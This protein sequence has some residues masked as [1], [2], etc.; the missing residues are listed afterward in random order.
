MKNTLL[1][2]LSL[3]CCVNIATAQLYVDEFDDGDASAVTGGA[4]YSFGEANGELTVTANG[5]SGPF[6]PFVINVHDQ[7]NGD[8]IT[9]DATGNNIVF[10]RA[11]ASNNG[12]QFRMDMQD[13]AGFATTLPGFTV[14][15]TTDYQVF[16]FDFTDNYL[17]GGFGGT[18][19]DS[20]DAPC[21]VDGTMI[22]QFIM[23]VNPQ[24]GGF[25][26]QVVIDYIAFGEEPGE[27]IMSDIFQDHM[28][29]DSSLTGFVDPGVGYTFSQ[30]GTEVIIV[31]D[32]S[33]GAWDPFVFDF[34]NETTYETTDID[35]TGNNKIYVKAKS[36]VAGTALRMDAQ[37]IDG[38]VS[39][40]GSITKLLTDADEYQILEYDYTG[41]LADLGF[42]GTPCT[43]NTAPCPVD[44]ERIANLTFFI[45]PGVGEY[46]GALTI[47][48]I[49]VGTSLEP[50]G[51]EAE[52][53]YSDHFNNETVDFVADAGGFV[54]S[55]TGSEWTIDGDG[56]A[57]A[58]SA[59]AY[60]FHDMI[61]GEG[62]LLDLNP[63]QGKVF[64]RAKTSGGT[65]PLR[66]DLVD[67]TGYVTS[68]PAL[69]K[70]VSDEYE[71]F[72][73][74]FSG[75]YIDGGYGGTAC[76]E[77]EGP[78]P[79]D[80]TVISTVLL[81]P[82]PDIGGY[83]GDLIIDY[84]SVGQPAGEDMGAT[85]LPE[86]TE[87]A[88][89][90]TGIFV[91][92][93]ESGTVSSFANDEW[94]ITGDGTG[95]DFDL[96]EYILHDDIGETSMLNMAAAGD[97]LY[98]RAKSD[99]EGATLRTDLTD[100]GGFST[101]LAGVTNTLTSEYATYQ[102]DF[103]GNYTDGGFGGTSCPQGG[104]ECPVDPQ[105]ITQFGFFVNAGPDIAALNGTVSIDWIS[106][107]DLTTNTDDVAGLD[108][109]HVYPNPTSSVLG[110]SYD[111]SESSEV[112]LR[113]YD[114][115]GRLLL[116]QNED[117]AGVGNNFTRLN[118]QSFNK[119]LYFL[120]VSVNGRNAKAVTVLKE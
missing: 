109:L 21:P 50:A 19:C 43:E 32:G 59:M 45:E 87:Q 61:N 111:L 16:S 24:T 84:I 110:V 46:V 3:F 30:S 37:D 34:R 69:T 72:E 4:A 97:V 40:Q 119:G 57:G 62:I 44:G 107:M 94:T 56:S 11:K 68:L 100:I 63:A 75:Q 102:Y 55:E 27:V 26:G 1:L 13:A 77:G 88:D 42:G 48:Y 120:Q 86:Y 60:S 51:P 28:D 66:V 103:A 23:F 99:F 101:T 6:D 105:R 29:N 67:S 117:N 108:A 76:P 53:V 114:V 17:D 92:D 47:D 20:G 70:V 15:L 52:F 74:N 41:V 64:L 78:C 9:A 82:D 10:V 80:P 14:S 73:Y 35:I 112:F 58:Y 38:F 22:N 90:N 85:G 91:N 118:I 36:S 33:T 116:E 104:G 89:D 8:D 115:T 106:T 39:T 71:I 81:Y 83:A 65:V 12:T 5:S 113:L 95:G 93:P 2:L 98:I 54:S 25:G 7:S 18:S 31:G 96:I 49:S 79:V